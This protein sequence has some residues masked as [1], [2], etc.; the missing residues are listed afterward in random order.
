[1]P[2]IKIITETELRQLVPLDLAAVDCVE[3]GFC[4]LAQ[5]NVVM[6]PIMS[7]PIREHNGEI[8]VKAAHVPGLDSFAVKMSPGFFDNPKLGLPSSSGMMVLF[9]SRTGMLEALLLDN[10]YLTDVRTAAAGAVAARHMARADAA[11]ACVIGA[12]MQ[13]RLQLE[14]LMLVRPIT[15]AVI[16]A[17]D[18]D[19]SRAVAAQLT[20]ELGISV[21][22]TSD[23][24]GA[25]S[26]ADVIITTTPA[27]DPLVMADWLRPGQLITAVGSDQE[28]KCELA[29]KCLTR[30]DFYVPDSQAQ[31]KERGELRSAI[32]AGLVSAEQRFTE[33]GEIAA[34]MAPARQSAEAIIVAD[35]T[36]AGVQ[37]IAIATYALEQATKEGIG[38][39]FA[40]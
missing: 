36:G 31:T 35:L 40:N 1:M 17:R 34:G 25:V 11:T 20:E 39:D 37:D 22:A 5:G 3:Q 26:S 14:A 30:A 4:A 6:P 19:N 12:G 32:A 16:W 29:P 24:E 2:N 38:S 33:L 18:P 21:A 15:S 9:S 27:T 28:H 10:G 23:A 7:M 8:C 13:A